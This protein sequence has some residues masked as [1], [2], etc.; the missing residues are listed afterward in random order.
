MR[1]QR[2]LGDALHHVDR[3]FHYVCR[4]A[5]VGVSPLFFPPDIQQLMNAVCAQLPPDARILDGNAIRL[6]PNQALLATVNLRSTVAQLGLP[7][8]IRLSIAQDQIRPMVASVAAGL[9]QRLL[10][11]S[12]QERQFYFA[13]VQQVAGGGGG[14]S[15]G[16][17]SRI[18]RS[19]SA[20]RSFTPPCRKWLNAQC[21]SFASLPGDRRLHRE[22]NPKLCFAAHHSGVG[23]SCLHE[24]I[25]LN[26]RPYTG[27][28]GEAQRIF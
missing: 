20:S 14:L 12:E 24:R 7:L 1:L 6:T 28:L 21:G 18:I 23:L 5:R 8:Y 13:V 22:D 26:H 3:R 16:P 11:V 9:R 17:C 4:L 27:Q 2:R 25:L 10:G 15:G 19:L